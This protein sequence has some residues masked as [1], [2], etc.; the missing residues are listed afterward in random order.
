MMAVLCII[1]ILSSKLGL[2]MYLC[3]LR[4]FSVLFVKLLTTTT[5]ETFTSFE[6]ASTRVSI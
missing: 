5:L 1:L 2:D 6:G 3:S 4:W